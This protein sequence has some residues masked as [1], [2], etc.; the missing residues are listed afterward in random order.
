MV[1]GELARDTP[2]GGGELHPGS[3][4]EVRN[5][6]DGAWSRGFEVAQMASGPDDGYRVRRRSDAA[7]L[8]GVFHRDEL[9][10]ERRHELWWF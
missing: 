3:H 8:P 7:V 4:V 5:R 2:A 6:F 10:R 9:R 1:D